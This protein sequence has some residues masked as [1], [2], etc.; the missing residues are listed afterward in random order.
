MSVT[1]CNNQAKGFI[2]FILF[3]LSIFNVNNG[4]A[5]VNT[6]SLSIDNYRKK[7]I[8]FQE[9]GRNTDSLKFYL[10]KLETSSIDYYEMIKLYLNSGNKFFNRGELFIAT[11]Y[12]LKAKETGLKNN[13]LFAATAGDISIAGVYFKSEEYSKANIY[14]SDAE[15]YL[16]E[17]EPK[18][19]KDSINKNKYMAVVLVNLGYVN[20]HLKDYDKAEY[21]NDKAIF[22]CDS[23]N[24]SYTIIGAYSNKSE[25]YLQKKDYD[26]AIFYELKSLEFSTSIGRKSSMAQAEVDLGEIYDIIEKQDSAIYYLK[27]GLDHSTELGLQE[28]IYL[29][30]EIL[31]GIYARLGQYETAYM[32]DTIAYKSYKKEVESSNISKIRDI[33][34]KYKLKLYEKEELARRNK[35]YI[36]ILVLLLITVLA[37]FFY[38]HLQLNIRLKMLENKK[39]IDEKEIIVK[40]L[41]SKNRKIITDVMQQNNRNNL[42]LTIA[43]NLKLFSEGLNKAQRLKLNKI[44]IELR[45]GIDK[46]VLNEFE[47]SFKDIHSDFYNK[48][49]EYNLTPVERRMAAFIKLNLSSKEI[50]DITGQNIK[51]IDVTRYR[52]RKKLGITNTD[53]NLSIFIT[54]L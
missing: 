48:L 8:Y 33:T 34:H 54:K 4:I 52:L 16:T 44:I 1:Q 2:Y 45:K 27:K 47:Y 23:T 32:Y 20:F 10:E 31:S 21:Y 50:S 3:T 49:T 24:N 19:S 6:D 41:E 25:L 13:N 37:L 53:I 11:E 5:Q 39:L 12:Y 7:V 46:S 26:A 29:S 30:S 15:K 38:R 14:L 35:Y 28:E 40:D 36:I 17:I 9:A 22:F 43:E 42:N 51:T 18:N